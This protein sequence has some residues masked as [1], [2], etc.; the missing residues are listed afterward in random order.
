MARLGPAGHG[1]GGVSLRSAWLRRSRAMRGI[2][3]LGRSSVWHGAATAWHR[4]APRSDG[5][6]PKRSARQW[7]GEAEQCEGEAGKS[8]AKQWGSGAKPGEAKA[9]NLPRRGA[10][11]THKGEGTW[12]K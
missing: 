11:V 9:Q 5:Y 10:A 6:A 12:K 4:E 1:E 3:G 7:Q 8:G 2:A